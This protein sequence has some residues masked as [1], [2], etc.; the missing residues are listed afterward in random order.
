M[1]WDA[2][3]SHASEDK[4]EFVIPLANRLKEYGVKIWLDKFTLKAGYG[5]RRSID[6]GLAKSK[7]GIVV[8]SN[9]FLNKNWPE[10]EFDSLIYRQVEGSKKNN[11]IIPIWHNVTKK[12]VQKYS[13]NLADKVA[14]DS[15]NM[16]LEQI[17]EAIIEIVRPDIYKTIENLNVAEKIYENSDVVNVNNSDFVRIIKSVMENRVK[18]HDELTLDTMLLIRLI[19]SIYKDVD[20]HTYND[21][22]EEYKYNLNPQREAL[23]EVINATIFLDITR[24]KN[25]SNE[26]KESILNVINAVSAYNNIKYENLDSSKISMEEFEDIRNA[27]NNFNPDISEIESHLAFILKKKNN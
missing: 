22:V 3:I 16:S 7:Y 12:Q 23:I 11:I 20:H 5:L 19:H 18:R 8:I 6:E 14:L 26:K 4:E 2:F 9:N 1:K 24:D 27:F 15:S 21:R 17:T 25:Y 13:L 10:Y